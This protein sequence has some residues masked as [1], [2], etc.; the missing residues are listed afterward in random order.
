MTLFQIAHQARKKHPPVE[1]KVREPSTRV[2]RGINCGPFPVLLFHVHQPDW[3]NRSLPMR[4]VQAGASVWCRGV[5]RIREG[6]GITCIKIVTRGAIA[7]TINGESRLL[8]PGDVYLE[9]HGDNEV[10]ETGPAGFACQRVLH[11]E[12]AMTEP[13]LAAFGLEHVHFIRPLDP[14]SI[15]EIMKE[16][17]R[18]I[19]R[20]DMDAD[21]QLSVLAY[22]LLVSLSN[23][24]EQQDLPELVRNAASFMHQHISIPANLELL[25]TGLGA[26]A[27]H[28]SRLFRAHLGISPIAHWN[29]MKIE[30]ARQLLLRTRKSVQQIAE[31]V[32]FEDPYYFSTAFR[33]HFG[34]SPSSIRKVA[35]DE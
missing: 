11:I 9:K 32:G 35:D 5:K 10:Y 12:G 15:R 8:R 6:C 3:T 7:C 27:T 33:K 28:L 16:A 14:E 20:R 22:R 29:R 17:S 34:R 13:L 26:S 24:L 1:H 21:A 19:R 2:T 23:A 31:E 25:T 18:I 30:Y 4:V